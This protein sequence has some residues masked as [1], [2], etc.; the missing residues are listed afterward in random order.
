MF[1]IPDY[2]K[3]FFTQITQRKFIFPFYYR[4]AVKGE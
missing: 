1:K 2:F 3:Y 4:E